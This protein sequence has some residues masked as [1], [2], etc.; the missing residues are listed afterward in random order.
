MFRIAP[1]K[2]RVIEMDDKFLLAN[3]ALIAHKAS[4]LSSAQRRLV[5]DRVAY[6]IKEGR[7]TM[8]RVTESVNKLTEFI[9]QSAQEQLNGTGENK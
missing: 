6:A 1:S 2:M 8:D 9:T 4:S 5:K 7:F 3:Y